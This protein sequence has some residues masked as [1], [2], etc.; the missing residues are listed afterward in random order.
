MEVALRIISWTWFF[1]VFKKSHAW[2]DSFFQERFLTCLYLHADFTMRH[3][4]YSDINGNHYTAD[5]AGLVFAGL[6]F[7]TG[8]EAKLWVIKAGIFYVMNSK[9]SIRR[10]GG[11]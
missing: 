5:A 6:F 2:Q 1:H 8:A 7:G 11:F 10:W 4:E 3:I 9:T